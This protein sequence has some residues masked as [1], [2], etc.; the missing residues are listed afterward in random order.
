MAVVLFVFLIL[1]WSPEIV[2]GTKTVM[3]IHY[4]EFI[5]KILSTFRASGRFIWCVGYII[6]LCCIMTVCRCSMKKV[7]Y[8][9][10][11]GALILQLADIRGMIEAKKVLISASSQI[12]SMTS[13]QWEQLA[14]GKEHLIILPYSTVQGERGVEGSYEMGNFAVGH[15]MTI[16]YFPVAR[17]DFEKIALNDNQYIEDLINGNDGEKN[18][19]ILDTDNRAKELGLTLYIV[20]GYRVGILQ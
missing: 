20:D 7:A 5:L 15:G 12:N 8:I 1:A 3:R 6:M 4:P 19:Y 17:L 14:E 13:D 16:N 2:F 11:A 18:M 10:A 9:C